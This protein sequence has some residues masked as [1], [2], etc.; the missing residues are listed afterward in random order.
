MNDKK[1]VLITYNKA[2]WLLFF[3]DSYDILI[4]QFEIA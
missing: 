1:S 2:Y 3:D 4:E